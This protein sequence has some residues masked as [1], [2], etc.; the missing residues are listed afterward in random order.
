[1]GFEGGGMIQNQTY[2]DFMFADVGISVIMY[3]NLYQ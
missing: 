2:P 3:S 1:M